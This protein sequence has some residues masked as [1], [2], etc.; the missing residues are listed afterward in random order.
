MGLAHG[1]VIGPLARV[2]V[3]GLVL[4]DEAARVGVVGLLG[5]HSGACV[6]VDGH[7]TAPLGAVVGIDGCT[8]GADIACIGVVTGNLAIESSSE[9]VVALIPASDLGP[10]GDGEGETCHGDKEPLFFHWG[11]LL[12]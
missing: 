9:G 6:G 7:A 10:S 1:E 2:G 4:I 12:I 5:G 8:H 3:V 11:A